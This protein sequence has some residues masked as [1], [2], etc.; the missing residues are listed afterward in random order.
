MPLPASLEAQEYSRWDDDDLDSQALG[1]AEGRLTVAAESAT[2]VA[3]D[4]ADGSRLD[5][6]LAARMPAYSRSRIQ[7]WIGNGHVTIDG[8]VAALRDPVWKDDRVRVE[9]QASDDQNAF[10]AEDIELDVVHEDEA[11]LVLNKRAGLVVHPAAGNWTGTVLNGLLHRTPSLAGVPRAGIVHR[12]DKDTSGLMVVARTIV[13]QTD[14]VRQL[15]ER[16]VGRAYVAIV[17][18]TPAPSGRIAWPIGRDPRDRTRMAAFKPSARGADDPPGTKPAATRFQTLASIEVARGKTVS[19]MLCRL[20]TG[21]THQIR[22][23]MQAIGHPLL[24]DATYGG[25]ARG[26]IAFAR[27]ALHAWHLKL[28][29]PTTRAVMEWRADLP[30][31]MATLARE[32]GFDI[33][34]LLLPALTDA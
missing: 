9:P 13:A 24:G 16:T 33:E 15:Q 21:R 22:V 8:R 7:R 29:H 23:H 27:Q 32:L 20:E 2:F 3:G 19:L 28:I 10:V 6:W 34:R 5:K 14:L 26:S 31:D 11:V 18:G 1:N 12:L 4:E 25:V 17:H 30:A